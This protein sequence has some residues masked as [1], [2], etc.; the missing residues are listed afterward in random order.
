[1]QIARRLMLGGGLILV[2]PFMTV[3]V[4]NAQIAD[5]IDATI[6]HSFI[7]SKKTLPPGKYVF[8]T[9]SGSEGGIMRVT[10]ADGKLSDEFLVRQSQAPM[11][12]AHTELIFRRYGDKEFLSKIYESGNKSG[13]AV[14]SVSAQEKELKA[15]GQQSVEHSE[16]GE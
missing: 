5:Q 12:P 4:S 16:G 7:V 3:Q 6:S 1:M 8:E 13:V 9:Q 11:R 2:V 14:S 15:Q 10:S